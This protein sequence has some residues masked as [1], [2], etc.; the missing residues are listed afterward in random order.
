MPAS[1]PD[2][3]LKSSQ[4]QYIDPQIHAILKAPRSTH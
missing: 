3:E 4:F 1:Q 2:H